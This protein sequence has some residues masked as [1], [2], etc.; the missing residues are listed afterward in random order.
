MLDYAG[1]EFSRIRAAYWSPD[2]NRLLLYGALTKTVE[3]DE[4]VP[5]AVDEGVPP[6]NVRVWLCVS[7]SCSF[8]MHC[9]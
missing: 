9:P 3:V 1:L 2:S 8:V 7:T 6:H 5:A 4:G